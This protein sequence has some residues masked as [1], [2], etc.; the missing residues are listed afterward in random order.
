MNGILIINKTQKQTSWQTAFSRLSVGKKKNKKKR[1]KHSSIFIDATSSVG[2]IK[3]GRILRL[4]H[5]IN[6]FHVTLS[7]E[8][9]RRKISD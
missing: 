6:P 1:K 4:P 7:V 2:E 9:S 5:R 8:N 3:A